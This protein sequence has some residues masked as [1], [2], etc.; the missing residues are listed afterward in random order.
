[1]NI[2]HQSCNGAVELR[3]PLWLCYVMAS[4]VKKQSPSPA[5]IRSLKYKF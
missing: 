4:V 3:Q 2:N 5:L 1:M